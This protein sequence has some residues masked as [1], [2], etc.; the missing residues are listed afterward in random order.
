VDEAFKKMAE[1]FGF[2][3]DD[4]MGGQS[5]QSSAPDAW[6]PSLNLYEVSDRYVVCVDLAGMDREKI[7]V[8]VQDRVLHIRGVRPKPAIP[9]VDES[10]GVHLMEID[11][12]KFHRKV[13]LPAD[14]H[15]SAVRAI[16]RNGYVWINLPR[17]EE[18]VD[19]ANPNE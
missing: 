3:I 15:V 11:S 4:L 18:K 19:D 2:L 12:G 7:D 1:Q 17:G 5:F 6:M 10:V 16:Y 14:V 9:D 13:T 8:F